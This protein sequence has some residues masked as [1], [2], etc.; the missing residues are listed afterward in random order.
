MNRKTHGATLRAAALVAALALSIAGLAAACGGTSGATGLLEGR[1]TLGPIT[2]VEQVGDEPNTRPYAA[3][4][5][6]ATPEGDVVATVE[7]GSD[8]TF[9]VRLAAGSYRL[10]PRSP[11]GR[12]LPYAA[13]VD[14][15]IAAGQTTRVIIAFDS[16]IR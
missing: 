6:V 4:V 3:T 15:T 14:A 5:D 8:G 2:P 12:P 13:P 10:V 16:G 9:S 11:P 7:S 1:V